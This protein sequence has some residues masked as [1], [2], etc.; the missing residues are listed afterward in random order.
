MSKKVWIVGLISV[1]ALVLA[2][3]AAQTATAAAETEAAVVAADTSEAQSAPEDQDGEAAPE[4]GEGREGRGPRQGRNPQGPGNPPGPRGGPG[5]GELWQAPHITGEITAIADG[6]FTMTGRDEDTELTVLI[7][8]ET[9]YIGTAESLSDL[10]VGDE[11]AVAGKRGDEEGT[12]DAR[13]IMLA[14]DLPLGIPVGGEVTAVT[15]NELTIELRDGISLTFAV[16]S[17]VDF[18][19]RDNSVASITDVVAGDHVVVVYEQNAD[20]TLTAKLILVAGEPPEG[21]SGS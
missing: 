19:S 4:Q 2:A 7:D 10:A 5:R 11:V 17:A 16:D 13:L 14:S 20:G 6:Q 18:L 21:D 3:C 15:S 8:E 9:A 12:L 1:A